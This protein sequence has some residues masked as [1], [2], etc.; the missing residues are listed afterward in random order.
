[1]PVIADN[2]LH[3][4][5]VAYAL[6]YATFGIGAAAGAFTV[7]SVF[8]QRSKVALLRPGFVLFA[9][10]LAAFGLVR[11]VPAAFVLIAIVGYLYFLVVTCLSTIIQRRLRDEQRGRVMALWIMFFGG[12]VP[13]GVLV[14]GPFAKSYSTEVLLVG[15]AWALVLAGF[16]G[17]RSLRAKGAPD[18]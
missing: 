14:A 4:S 15:A 2:N 9:V 11:N 18:D 6:L 5:D 16:S 3:L 13:L 10:A 8:A 1:M 7:G 12:T 17:A